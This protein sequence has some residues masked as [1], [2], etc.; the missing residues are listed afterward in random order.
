MSR[1]HISIVS[2]FALAISVSVWARTSESQPKD[3][4]LERTRKQ[5]RMLDDIYKTTV[6]LIT[7]KYVHSEKDFPAGSAAVALFDAMKKKGW[8]EVRLLDASGKPRR[9]KNVA[10][11]AFEKAA[12]SALKS[13]KSYY[14]EVIRDGAKR[15]LRAATA[16]PVVSEKCT[17]CH[18]H[19]EDAAKGEAIGALSYTLTIE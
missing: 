14:E 19:F 16:I 3:A 1:R 12:V 9:R 8:H 11:D 4:A 17:M 15:K 13:G 5:V 10:S 2:L 6:V 18:A 7:D